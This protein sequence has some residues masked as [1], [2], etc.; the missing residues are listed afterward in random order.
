MFRPM[1]DAAG[2]APFL[3]IVATVSV[4]VFGTVVAR[5]RPGDAGDG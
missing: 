3:R 1:V 4:R 2:A 5:R